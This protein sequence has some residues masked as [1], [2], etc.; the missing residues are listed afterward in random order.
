MMMAKIQIW[1]SCASLLMLLLVFTTS[2]GHQMVLQDSEEIVLRIRDSSE[3]FLNLNYQNFLPKHSHGS[4]RIHQPQKEIISTKDTKFKTPGGQ[5]KVNT[6]YST[7]NILS[8]KI[9]Y[10]VQQKQN[11]I[12]TLKTLSEISLVTDELKDRVKYDVIQE[13]PIYEQ[14]SQ[15]RDT[16]ED[17]Y[18]ESDSLSSSPDHAYMNLCHHPPTK[19]SPQFLSHPDDSCAED[20]SILQVESTLT[21]CSTLYISIYERYPLYSWF[22]LKNDTWVKVFVDESFIAFCLP[23]FQRFNQCEERQYMTICL[24]EGAVFF[25]FQTCQKPSVL[26]KFFIS[27][28]VSSLM[29]KDEVCFNYFC[30]GT[31]QV[32][33]SNVRGVFFRLMNLQMD[34]KSCFYLFNTDSNLNH[35]N[36]T[37]YWM[38]NIHFPCCYSQYFILWLGIPED[39]GVNSN[40]DFLPLTCRVSE[41]L[42]VS[43][44]GC[45]GVFG[46]VG[47]LIVL[48][49]MLNSEHK[50][51]ES[52]MLRTSLA[53]ADLCI[54]VFVVVPS[55][56]YQVSLIRGTLLS[57]EYSW[58][59]YS[60]L[61]DLSS[62]IS[63]SLNQY[64]VENIEVNSYIIYVVDSGY[65]LFQ[66]FTMSLCSQVSIFTLLLLSVE[67]YI[68][69]TLSLQYYSYFSVFRIKLA[70]IFTWSFGF[71][72][73][74][75]L[76]YEGNGKFSATWS[77]ITKL[78]IGV[79]ERKR[80]SMELYTTY[81]VYLTLLALVVV[82][83]WILSCLSIKNF[84]LEQRRVMA[85]W[86]NLHLRV[87][88]SIHKE[89]RCIMITMVLIT[90]LFS[91]SVFPLS[92]NVFFNVIKYD[93]Y[94]WNLY[95]YISW[96]LF[97][98]GHAWNPWIYNMRSYQ[99]Q[100]D[101]KDTFKR[102]LPT[103]FKPYFIQCPHKKE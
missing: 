39:H 87:S 31:F 46:V 67:R 12:T 88:D 73:T 30:D 77:T 60:D 22:N 52:S 37:R 11:S 24:E 53:F 2:H 42:L 23:L 27:L 59:E 3:N 103:R 85:E 20:I 78:P 40:W 62:N 89:N 99:F 50:G 51:Q 44:T 102:M 55:V 79:T 86:K 10:L 18:T 32:I 19:F 9:P 26:D 38:A 84:T 58:Q 92:I 56:T 83:T 36:D 69:T 65:R 8:G 98:A 97:L 70:I 13:D 47:N 66:A 64:K 25:H 48:V 61:D 5:R 21:L 41:L 15:H 80:S 82:F 101:M 33:D 81:Y 76:M 54:G 71:I 74:F 94:W 35:I 57:D 45:I 72:Q 68:M 1:P 91:V 96:W 34:G 29:E 95:S 7:A 17:V 93:F 28:L 100:I 49:V 16:N 90:F 75:F 43:V 4:S 6:K 63:T 14:D